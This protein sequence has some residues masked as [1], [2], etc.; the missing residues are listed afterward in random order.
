MATRSAIWNYFTVN[1]SNSDRGRCN[2][3]HQ[4]YSC[5]S[6]TTSSLINHLKS[7]HKDVLEKYEASNTKK[8]P[9][10]QSAPGQSS[11]K[12]PKIES[13]IPQ[14]D[15]ALNKAFDNAMV[16]FLA[17]S[18]VAFRVAGLPSFTNLMSIA[19]RRIKVKHPMTYNRMVKVKA[20]DIKKDLSH[21]FTVAKADF[22][23]VGFT[24]DMWTSRSGNPFMSLTV[25]FISKDWKL[26][27]FTPY[28][29]PFPARH[30]GKN[31]SLSLDA[32]VEELG[33]ADGHWELFAVN[34]NAAN[35]KLGIKLSQYLHQY[36]CDIHTLELAVKDCFKNTP[37]M[38]KVV[39]KCKAIGKFTHQSTVAAGMLKKEAI[40]E[41]IIFRKVV[42]PPSTRWSGHFANLASVL[43]LKKPLTNLMASHDDWAEH[44]LSVSDWK[45]VE[46]A[47]ELLKPV[48]DTVKALEAEK[49]PTMHRVVERIYTMHSQIDNFIAKPS[50]NRYGVGFARE[51]KKQIEVRFPEVGTENKLRCFANFLAPQYKGIHL[52]TTGKLETTKDDIKREVVRFEDNEVDSELN[53]GFIEE[54]TVDTPPLSPTSQLRK[55]K[56]A[57]QQRTHTG[58]QLENRESSIDKELRRYETFSLAPKDVDILS[59]WKSHENVLP[60]LAKLAKKVLT[61]P[62][63]SAKSERVFSCGGNFVT[64]KRN[65][66]GSQ[67]VEELILMKENKQQIAEFKEE[68]KDMFT[69]L[70]LQSEPFSRV[71]VEAVLANLLN[72]DELEEDMFEADIVAP[73]EEEM[74][75]INALSDVESDNEESEVEIV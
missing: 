54:D 39:K 27:R 35:V 44:E 38:S 2:T 22:T 7:K 70:E 43:H 3:C 30:T 45:L 73:G 47:V 37:G 46:G 60:L 40:R 52:E 5:K 67:K 64:P 25:H 33:L 16:E 11:S 26:Y 41:N 21:I 8:R 31:I 58:D 24:T 66:L 36:L 51:L 49:E 61:I 55:Q 32:M 72:E 74:I 1:E 14:N 62:A 53:E 69:A 63:S 34:D 56:K 18:G 10:A 20:D 19:N 6:G 17:D 75:F 48:R 4:E 59:W 50:N 29:A 23:C 15:T 9:V 42:N 28:V 71:S 68:H 57:R 13:F 65:K 12:Q